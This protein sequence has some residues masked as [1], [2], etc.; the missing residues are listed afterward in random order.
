MTPFIDFSL[1]ECIAIAVCWTLAGLMV[2]RL[3]KNTDEVSE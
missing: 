2:T 1:S 3:F